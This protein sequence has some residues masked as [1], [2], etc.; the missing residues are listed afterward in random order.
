MQARVRCVA[1]VHNV[2]HSSDVV[3]LAYMALLDIVC[4]VTLVVSEF[5]VLQFSMGGLDMPFEDIK[6]SL[7]NWV[8]TKSIQLEI[9]R[10]FRGFLEAYKDDADE[11]IYRKRVKD[12]CI[13][14][15]T[16]HWKPLSANQCASAFLF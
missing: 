1:A 10:R 15:H 14:G 12:M 9:K 16:N 7:S 2:L 8:T 4:H 11:L 13:G 6:G 3:S 5:Y